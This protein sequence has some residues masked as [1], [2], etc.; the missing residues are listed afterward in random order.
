MGTW[1]VIVV[2]AVVVVSLGSGMFYLISDRS[3]STR[4]VKALTIRIALSIALIGL[5]F[6]LYAL[7]LIHPH[8]VY[9]SQ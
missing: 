3:D 1:I 7:G 8:G 9:P 6:V 5:L 4:T 2:L